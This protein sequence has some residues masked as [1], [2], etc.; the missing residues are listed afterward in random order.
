MLIGHGDHLLP[1]ISGAL[2]LSWLH[3]VATNAFHHIG[4]PNE[5]L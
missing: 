5:K 2:F 4:G 3:Q 1:M